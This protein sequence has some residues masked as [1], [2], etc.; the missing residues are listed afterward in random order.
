MRP[1]ADPDFLN[2]GSASSFSGPPPLSYL[3]GEVRFLAEWRAGR[4]YCRNL[5][6]SVEGRRKTIMVIPGFLASD[7]M[8][9]VLRRSLAA[10]GHD[11]HGWSQ[12]RNLGLRHGVIDRL[13]ESIAGLA[14][15]RGSPIVLIGWSLGGLYAR[16]VA[17]MLP[18]EVAQVITLASP[19]SGD[20][21]ANNAWRLYE[22]IAGHNVDQPPIPVNLAEKPPQPTCA[23]WS[24]R[25]GIVSSDSARGRPGEA[26]ATVEVDCT[27]LGFVCA[28][29][30][31]KAIISLLD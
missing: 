15:G 1:E 30:S 26:D 5:P 6:G 9:G 13:V 3:L 14:Q 29:V 12:G 28:P 4:Q 11:V 18:T 17:K 10:V 27:H 23:L 16:E 22:W 21:R 24:G 19:F 31:I 25:D 8:T 20:I 7:W 2:K